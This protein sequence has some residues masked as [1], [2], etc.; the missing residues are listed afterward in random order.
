[1]KKLKLKSWVKYFLLG[2]LIG[3]VSYFLIH[4]ILSYKNRISNISN[5]CDDFYGRTCSWYEVE[6]F[7][8]Q[9]S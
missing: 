6:N 2:V 8:G 3:I 5:Q 7:K 4:F 9:A 1:M